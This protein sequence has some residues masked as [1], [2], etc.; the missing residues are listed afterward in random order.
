MLFRSV[1]VKGTIDKIE[2][3]NSNSVSIV[4]YKTGTYN[5]NK[6]KKRNPISHENGS[7]YWNQLLFYKLL[8]EQA[9][10]MQALVK[11]ATLEWVEAD[12]KGKIQTH[13]IEFSKDDEQ[14]MEKRIA[15]TY[16]KILQHD[17]YKGCG[18]KDCQWCNFV[19]DFKTPIHFDVSVSEGLDDGK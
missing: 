18:K 17:F 8:Y 15:T 4:D 14:W 7:P 19:N 5:A 6:I 12:K 1:P 16:D 3:V 13:D 10:P 2:L 11:K 9:R